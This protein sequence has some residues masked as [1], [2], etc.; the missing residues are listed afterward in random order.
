MS[1]DADNGKE[2]A[3]R[4]LLTA[5]VR[6]LGLIPPNGTLA[7]FPSS[8]DDNRCFTLGSPTFLATET[9]V[10]GPIYPSRAGTLMDCRRADRRCQATNES[11][12]GETPSVQE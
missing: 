11:A 2:C 5:L 4:M 1:I 7:I 10:E 6:K 9:G 3:M 12:E 8:P